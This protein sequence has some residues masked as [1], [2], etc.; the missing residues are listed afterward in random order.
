MTFPSITELTDTTLLNSASSD[1][2]QARALELY[3]H[4]L[5][6]NRVI[7]A[8][9]ANGGVVGTKSNARAEETLITQPEQIFADYG[10][11]NNNI[12]NGVSTQLEWGYVD[13]TFGDFGT[14]PTPGNVIL[15]VSNIN[16]VLVDFNLTVLGFSSLSAGVV[17]LSAEV[18]LN[19][20]P[21]SPKVK[22]W[23]YPQTINGQYSLVGASY[24][25]AVSTND[26]LE[27]RFQHSNTSDTADVHGFMTAQIYR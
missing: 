7:L 26:I 16:Y 2:N 27:L 15:G 24:P 22:A 25:I 4:T 10:G 11:E 20:S 13:A 1:P 6:F 23:A 5:L 3:P 14:Q 9:N 17:Y 18:W 19:G 8:R 21:L 12:A